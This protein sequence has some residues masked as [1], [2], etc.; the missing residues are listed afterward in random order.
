MDLSQIVGTV[1]KVADSS[2]AKPATPLEQILSSFN[3]D[4]SQVNKWL[5]GGTA[6]LGLVKGLGLLGGSKTDSS[7]KEQLLGQIGQR[8]LSATT[9]QK[10]DAANATNMA[11]LIGL[12][13]KAQSFVKNS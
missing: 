10:A 9:A 8:I 1:L 6:V 7:L 5:S 4:L 2:I 13:T 11:D 12:L 3:L